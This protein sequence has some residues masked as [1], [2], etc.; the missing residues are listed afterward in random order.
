[1]LHTAGEGPGGDYPLVLTTGRILYHYL[2][3]TMTR[4]VAALHEM[5]PDGVMEINPEDA[6][7]AGCANGDIVE[8]EARRRAG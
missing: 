3:G 4:K 2:T 1:M 6:A 8:V 5:R 7:A